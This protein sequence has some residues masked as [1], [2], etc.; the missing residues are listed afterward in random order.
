M[1]KALKVQT[2]KKVDLFF[3]YSGYQAI[4]K[5][6]LHKL[7]ESDSL[8]IKTLTISNCNLNDIE[9]YELLVF[10][11]NDFNLEYLSEIE[12]SCNDITGTGVGY[13]S[14]FLHRN[15]SIQIL[16]LA[17][18][19]LLMKA[20]GMSNLLKLIQDNPQLK[21]LSL[22]GCEI[23]DTVLCHLSKAIVSSKLKVLDL[24]ENPEVTKVGI[25][26]LLLEYKRSNEHLLSTLDLSDSDIDNELEEL[27]NG[28]KGTISIT[29]Y[30][31][32]SSYQDGESET[33]SSVGS[34]YSSPSEVDLQD[35]EIIGVV[36]SMFD[37]EL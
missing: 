19:L 6:L 8:I 27:V 9:L 35:S 16:E 17:G 7:K 21:D 29:F 34:S 23:D 4:R 13:L 11:S 2:Y 12:V 14:D 15:K 36:P 28:L 30:K 24:R 32:G 20:D 31:E 22:L 1:S 37:F 3:E 25:K 26:N 10:L 18:N 33:G 5:E